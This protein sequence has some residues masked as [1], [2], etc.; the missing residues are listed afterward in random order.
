MS[1]ATDVALTAVVG[2]LD[3]RM[4][5]EYKRAVEIIDW[6]VKTGE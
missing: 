4:L 6:F 1:F 2:R 5:D 3:G